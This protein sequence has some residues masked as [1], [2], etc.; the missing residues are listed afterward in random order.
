L[1]LDKPQQAEPV[2]GVEALVDFFRGGEKFPERF[3]V[4]MEHE[5]IGLLTGTIRPVPYAGERGIGELLRRLER[6]DYQPHLENGQPIAAMQGDLGITLEPGGQLELSGRPFTC[7]HDLDRE[8]GRHLAV[9]HALGAELGQTWLGVGYRPFGTVADAEWMPKGRYQ[10]MRA[11]LSQQGAL[12]LDMMT[13][14]GTVQANFDYSDE[15]DMARKV[16]VGNSVSPIVTALF[17]NSP[18]RDGR[19]CG[20][21][22][23]RNEVWRQMDPARCG[24]LEVAFRPDFGY[25]AYTEWALDVPM[26]FLRRDSE[27]RDPGGATFRR[28]L[29]DGLGGERATLSDWEDHLSTLFPEIRLKRVVE[30]RGADAGSREMCA[31]LPTL[32]KGLFY[33][34]DALDA[35]DRLLQIPFADRLALSND[36]SRLALGAKVAGRSVL[37]LA[38]ELVA[39]SAAGL[40]RQL[41]CGKDEGKF[42][43]PLRQ[44]LEDGRCPAEIAL[45]KLQGEYG[46]DARKLV[47]HWRIA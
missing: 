25:R 8:L 5:K 35:A 22:T 47:E 41:G 31:A 4:G 15:A 32:W 21:L 26:I 40:H 10:R 39:I 29:A 44:I 14:T 18:L 42:L 27:Y 24:L 34:R 30:V 37:E 2:S 16:R 6:F 19:E 20:Y 3:R 28:F 23:F 7:S 11:Y 17:A 36:V 1:S 46:G 33:D 13:M 9:I 12:A 38:R 43:E 45:A